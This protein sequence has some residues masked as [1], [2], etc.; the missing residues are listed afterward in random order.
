M[1][2]VVFKGGTGR[3]WVG[4]FVVF[5]GVNQQKTENGE[6]GQTAVGFFHQASHPRQHFCTRTTDTN[7]DGGNHTFF[8]N[9]SHTTSL[10]GL[11]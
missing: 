3:F 1:F 2:F 10:I 7:D 8:F 6:F 5:V 9:R 11:N 4:D